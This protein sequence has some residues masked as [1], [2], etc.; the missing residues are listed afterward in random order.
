MILDPASK[1]ARYLFRPRHLFLSV[2]L[3]RVEWQVPVK[4]FKISVSW[5]EANTFI[6]T[7][8]LYSLTKPIK[9]IVSEDN[10]HDEY[11]VNN[12]L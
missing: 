3:S 2:Y 10:E 5:L 8:E 7:D 12:Q 11:A 6:K 9:C 4:L 1:W